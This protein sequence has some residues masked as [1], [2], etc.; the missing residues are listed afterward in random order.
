MLKL[1][2]PHIYIYIYRIMCIM[3]TMFY[4]EETK[5]LVIKYKNK[6]WVRAKTAANIFR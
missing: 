6:I 5:L 1:Y 2:F 3:K 4:Y